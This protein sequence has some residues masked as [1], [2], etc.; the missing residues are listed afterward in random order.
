[1]SKAKTISKNLADA[2]PAA[3][4]PRDELIALGMLATAII[5]QT[6]PGRA[7]R[8]SIRSATRCARGGIASG[9]N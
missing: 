5:C 1:M 9:L 2:L 7:P 4:D 3:A 8:W 6:E